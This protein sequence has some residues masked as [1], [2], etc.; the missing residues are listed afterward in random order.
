MKTKKKD[1][2]FSK[3]VRFA[4]KIKAERN[5]VATTKS[6]GQST[7]AD[8]F[9]VQETTEKCIPV[10]ERIQKEF[11]TENVINRS[12]YKVISHYASL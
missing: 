1:P 7:E 5:P 11:K 2:R 3:Y 12:W 8:V 10:F 9:N 6:F 4:N